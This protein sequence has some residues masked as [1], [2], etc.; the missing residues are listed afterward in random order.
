[1]LQTESE[2][3][4]DFKEESGNLSKEKFNKNSKTANSDPTLRSQ[5]NS[6]KLNSIIEEV[7]DLLESEGE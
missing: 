3:N 7:K 1:M 2:P 5:R 4:E 6:Q